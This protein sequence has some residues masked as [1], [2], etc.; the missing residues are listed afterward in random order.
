MILFCSLSVENAL[1]REC[2]IS[3]VLLWRV[4]LELVIFFKFFLLPW[5][6]SSTKKNSVMDILYKQKERAW[7]NYEY[8]MMSDLCQLFGMSVCMGWKTEM[9]Y[10]SRCW[11]HAI[12][13]F[14]LW[15][16]RVPLVARTTTF[17]TVCPI[18]LTFH[19]NNTLLYKNILI[20][21]IEDEK[22]RIIR[23]TLYYRQ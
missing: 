13:M 8:G 7:V 18:L 6:S 11:Q 23:N 15:Y 20:L 9:R 2:Y 17:T 12:W 16:P 14:L 10:M 5:Y 22:T 3:D 19:G 4:K 21:K 1:W